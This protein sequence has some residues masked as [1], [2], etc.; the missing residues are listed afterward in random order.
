MI[1]TQYTFTNQGGDSIT[2]N[3]HTT[4]PNQIIALQSY[5]QFDVDIKSSEINKEGQHGVWDFFSYYGRR[6][7]TFSGVIVGL[8]ETDV[9]TVKN[10]LLKVLA[11]PSQP[12]SGR[13]GT[14]TLVWTDIESRTWQLTGKLMN[15]IQFNRN[16]KETFRLDFNFSLKSADPF[17][18]AQTPQTV[19][20]TRGYTRIGA[21]FPISMPTTLGV[22]EV[23]NFTVNNGGSA[24]AQSIIR[25]YGES[26]GDI[27][28]PKVRNLTTG[29]YIQLSTTIVGASNYIEIDS[30]EGTIVNQSGTDLSNTITGDSRFLLLQQGANDMIYTSDENPLETLEL[31]TATI[32]VTFRNTK[33]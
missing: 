20:G 24:Y 26:Q 12:R 10:K 22:V 18:V 19:V 33:I 7:T 9:E 11:F 30:Q 21:Q 15:S 1:S 23:G 16:M 32:T 31:P 4:N 25:I 6:V 2:I 17:I 28:N 3:D 8:T 13:D 27:T 14:V 29:E 5:P